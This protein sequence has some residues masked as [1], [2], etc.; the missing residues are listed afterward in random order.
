MLAFL[1]VQENNF[2]SNL[3]I[4]EKCIVTKLHQASSHMCSFSTVCMNIVA[5][6]EARL[7]LFAFWNQ[8]PKCC[9]VFVVSKFGETEQIQEK[10][11]YI[12]QEQIPWLK[13]RQMYLIIKW[14]VVTA[15]MI[16]AITFFNI[17]HHPFATMLFLAND[18]FLN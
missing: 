6:R 10:G 8:M 13:I 5:S 2:I 9:E 18:L 11:Q 1:S 4:L 12:P 15:L 14:L 3:Y 7:R 16:W 17:V